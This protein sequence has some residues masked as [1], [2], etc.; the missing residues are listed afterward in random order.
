MYAKLF[1]QIF[2]S[3]VMDLPHPAPYV[4]ICLL[5]LANRDGVVDMTPTAIAGRVR[6]PLDEIRAAI[7]RLC[8]P[9][10]MSRSTEHEGRRLI[11]VRESYGWR[12]VNYQRYREMKREEDRAAY[13]RDY[14]R[15]YRVSKRANSKQPLVALAEAEANTKA[16]AKAKKQFSS[17][18]AEARLSRLLFEC[19]HSHDPHAKKPNMSE[20]AIAFDA[21]LRIDDRSIDEVEAVI[22]WIHQ[23][24][25]WSAHNLSPSK[26]RE[27]YTTLLLQ[28]KKTR[29]DNANANRND[30]FSSFD[31]RIAKA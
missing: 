6:L 20:W 8:E 29:K 28:M 17:D 3:T 2:D 13:M 23:N 4:W 27:K 7:V 18:S 5:A 30:D 24:Y 31:E 1:T 14:M 16:E 19:I 21:I 12:I 15:D 22:R 9:D 26:L 10:P 25:F 11:P